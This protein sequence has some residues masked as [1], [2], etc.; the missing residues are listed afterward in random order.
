MIYVVRHGQ[1]D[2]NIEHR[3]QGHQDIPLNDKG[4]EEANFLKDELS[5]IDFDLVFSSPLKRAYKTAEI[6]TKKP[7]R[8][9]DR[10]I[11][12]YNGK[13][14][15]CNDLDLIRTLPWN[16]DIDTEYEYERF[17]DLRN[18]VYE[19]LDEIINKYQDKNILIV[20]HAGTGIQIRCYF[21]GEPDNKNYDSYRIHN[22]EVLKYENKK[23]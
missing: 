13:L 2:W 8:I 21:E 6:I 16:E 23:I 18:R 11:E 7:I 3:I 4:V 19:F 1:T 5:D 17:S 20:T 14:E 10:L 22:C 9:D 12:R 15:G